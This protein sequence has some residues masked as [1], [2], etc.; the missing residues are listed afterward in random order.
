MDQA[1]HT[2]F[3]EPVSDVHA[4]VQPEGHRHHATAPRQNAAHSEGELC[5]RPALHISISLNGI[6]LHLRVYFFAQIYHAEPQ[7]RSGQDASHSDPV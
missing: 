3:G 1:G 4:R 6:F 2:G 5:V 7:S